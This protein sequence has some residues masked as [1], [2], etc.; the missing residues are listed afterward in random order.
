MKC[1]KYHNCIFWPN[2]ILCYIIYLVVFYRFLVKAVQER[3]FK[4]VDENGAFLKGLDL[5]ALNIQVGQ[6]KV[7]SI[8][9]H[10]E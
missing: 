3:L 9:G 1:D 8:G 10:V 6:I 7:Q 4:T 5:A 2:C